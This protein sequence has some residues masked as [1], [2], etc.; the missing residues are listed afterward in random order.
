MSRKCSY[1]VWK[2]H[3]FASR[4]FT[5]A[6]ENYQNLEKETLATIWEMKCFHYFLYGKEFTLETDQKP[7]ISIYKKHIVD[8]SSRIRRLII[9]S[10]S[11][12]FQIVY[13]PG[14]NIPVADALS[15]VSPGKGN[16]CEENSIKL[17][18]I[19]V[20]L[21]IRATKGNMLNEI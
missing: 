9:C 17:L 12:N 18:I 15:Y 8:V 13:V 1:E 2:G 7:L 11:N 19:M 14:R 6:E 20:N 4:S 16:E 5:K 21:V 3:N 10:L